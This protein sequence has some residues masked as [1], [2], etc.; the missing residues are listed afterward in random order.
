MLVI[1]LHIFYSLYSHVQD[2]FT[3]FRMYSWILLGV[4]GFGLGIGGIGA[5][6][7][8]EGGARR[9]FCGALDCYIWLIM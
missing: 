7:G 6:G 3:V 8:G 1:M 2:L 9:R 5:E 4:G